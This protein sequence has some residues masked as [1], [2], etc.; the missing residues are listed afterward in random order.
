MDDSPNEASFD[1]LSQV[2]SIEDVTT[3]EEK[4]LGNERSKPSSA[5]MVA[6]KNMKKFAQKNISN[7]YG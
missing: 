2:E 3:D 7:R 5:F 1:D 4:G 6:L